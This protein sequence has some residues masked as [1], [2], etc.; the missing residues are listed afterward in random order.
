MAHVRSEQRSDRALF[1]DG[2]AQNPRYTRG[3]VAGR[4]RETDP[5][6]LAGMLRAGLTAEQIA[7]ELGLAVRTIR[8]TIKRDGLTVVPPKPTGYRP[9]KPKPENPD[10]ITVEPGTVIT[11]MPRP[12]IEPLPAVSEDATPDELRRRARATLAAA[13]SMVWVETGAA[14]A[15]A[16]K[17]LSMYP[18]PVERPP[19]AE[20]TELLERVREI[21]ATSMPIAV[22][23]GALR[24]IEK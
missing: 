13:C 22:A 21:A 20:R 24:V 4:P 10:A 19:V 5:A 12:E 16:A 7:K 15:A 11:P 8:R 2:I 17:I 9:R 3:C 23:P 18:E 6:E 14:V 1:Q